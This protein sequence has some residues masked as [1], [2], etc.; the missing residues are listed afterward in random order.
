MENGY[1]DRRIFQRFLVNLPLKVLK[2]FSNVEFHCKTKDISPCGIGIIINEQLK[3]HTRLEM[4]LEI[5]DE[6]EPLYT[7]GEVVWS[8]MIG[9]NIYAA[10]IALAKYDLIGMS[11]VIRIAHD[12]TT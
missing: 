5:P 6:H 11:R 7:Q 9:P 4:W 10:D 12:Q 8:E 1:Q 2:I 3:P